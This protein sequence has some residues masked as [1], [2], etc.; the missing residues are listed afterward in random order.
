MKS[1]RK[2]MIFDC[3]KPLNTNKT[4]EDGWC[5]YRLCSC[6]KQ[7]SEKNDQEKEFFTP[8]QFK[9]PKPSEAVECVRSNF[10]AIT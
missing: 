4:S 7:K 8:C 2:M 5:V 1:K 3:F 10:D 6:F 9:A